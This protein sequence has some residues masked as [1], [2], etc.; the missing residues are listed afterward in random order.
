MAWWIHGEYMAYMCDRNFRG[1]TSQTEWLFESNLRSFGYFKSSTAL[2]LPL[3]PSC[4]GKLLSSA[5]WALQAQISTWCPKLDIFKKGKFHSNSRYSPVW[6]S[7]VNQNN[8]FPKE[9]M[10]DLKS[11]KFVLYYSFIAYYIFLES[12]LEVVNWQRVFF[13][14]CVCITQNLLREN[15]NQGKNQGKTGQTPKETITTPQE[16]VGNGKRNSKA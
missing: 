10:K 16:V 2:W 1:K 4:P 3:D 8:L 14:F 5:A 13:C 7:M 12:I 6:V 9:V 15:R 11:W